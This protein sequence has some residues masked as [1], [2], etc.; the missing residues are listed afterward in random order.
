MKFKMAAIQNV[1]YENMYNFWKK[2]DSWMIVMSNLGVLGMGDTMVLSRNT[3]NVV[4][5]IKSN[6]AA[7]QSP[8]I[9]E[10]MY[11]LWKKYDR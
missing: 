10:N 2:H 6:M 8:I 11:N 5:L 3:Y 1:I 7:I 9:Y 4:L